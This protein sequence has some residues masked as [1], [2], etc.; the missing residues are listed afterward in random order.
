[1]VKEKWIDMRV[2]SRFSLLIHS[3]YR[4]ENI[5]KE[6]N[7]LVFEFKSYVINSDMKLF[8]IPID[9]P[10]YFKLMSFVEENKYYYH[11]FYQQYEKS[12]TKKEIDSADFYAITS[13]FMLCGYDGECIWDYFHRCCGNGEFATVQYKDYEMPPKDI[14]RKQLFEMD[15]YRTGVSTE[16]KN[17][18]DSIKFTG[19]DFRP[20]WSRKDN[21]EPAGF[22]LKARTLPPLS[23]WN[24]WN[25]YK[26]C[27]HCGKIIYDF[28][29]PDQL[30]I[31]RS[32]SNNLTDFSETFEEFTELCFRILLVS[33]NVYNQLKNMGVKRLHVEPIRIIN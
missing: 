17:E 10:A 18:F 22:Q 7:E 16:V 15:I 1:M 9:N 32:I 31:P 24:K 33:R 27:P 2:Y 11:N 13:G 29:L 19:I 6:I 3:T 20:I 23:Q 5:V 4:P 28:N 21:N 12:F 25:I 14:L 8:K 30:T 26:T